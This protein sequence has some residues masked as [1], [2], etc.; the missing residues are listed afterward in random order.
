ML[1]KCPCVDDILKMQGQTQL[2]P[3]R[4]PLIYAGGGAGVS[5]TALDA[6]TLAKPSGSA[7]IRETV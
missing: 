5:K 7:D 6:R 1:C 4:R 3:H 2:L